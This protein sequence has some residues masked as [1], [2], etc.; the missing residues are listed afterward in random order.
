MKKQKWKQEEFP[1]SIPYVVA[2]V[3]LRSKRWFICVKHSNLH[4]ILT[5]GWYD[6]V[7]M[8]M[9]ESV[10]GKVGNDATWS[11]TKNGGDG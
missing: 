8:R 6:C 10:M 1:E 2:G 9:F 3:W 5:V 11:A 7:S 4:N